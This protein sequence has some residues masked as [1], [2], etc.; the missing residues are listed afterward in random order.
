MIKTRTWIFLILILLLACGTTI[1]IMHF[2]QPKSLVV[3][4]LQDGKSIKEIDLN[5]VDEPYSL[6]IEDRAGGKNAIRV[7][8]GRIRISKADCPDRI[9][10]NRGWL[11]EENT[12]P[13]V[14][15]PHKLMIQLVGSDP[16]L[17]TMA[18]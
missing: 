12:A 17:D 15:L 3:E 5:A 8:P 2:Q 13:I 9:C 7:E 6:T 1:G 16:D 18:Q 10:V 4:I 11:S 14:C